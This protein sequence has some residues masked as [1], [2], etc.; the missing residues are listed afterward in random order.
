MAKLLRAARRSGLQPSSIYRQLLLDDRMIE[1]A[2]L[3]ASIVVVVAGFLP[4]DDHAR[5]Q[6]DFFEGRIRQLNIALETEY[7]RRVAS[8]PARAQLEQARNPKR[9]LAGSRE[10]SASR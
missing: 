3:E 8:R 9:L 1:Y 5:H 2:V 7:D 4:A 10:P 6:H